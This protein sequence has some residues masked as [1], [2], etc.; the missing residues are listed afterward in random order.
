M[1]VCPT[2]LKMNLDEVHKYASANCAALVSG[3]VLSIPQLTSSSLDPGE[4]ISV[5]GEQ[6]AVN[7]E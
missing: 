5:T 6:I 3:D 7:F 4:Q 2:V 1:L